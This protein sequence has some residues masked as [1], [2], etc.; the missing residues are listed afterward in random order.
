MPSSKPNRTAQNPRDQISGTSGRLF[1]MLFSIT[2][3]IVW[4]S[5][6][7]AFQAWKTGYDQKSLVGRDTA[8]HIRKLVDSKPAGV[9]TTTWE[10][11]VDH[12]EAMLIAVTGSNLLSVPQI[13]E[14]TT[15]IDQCVEA[16]RRNPEQGPALLRQL[17][18]ELANRAGPVAEIYGRPRLIMP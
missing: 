17:W 11:A 15:E 5:L 2:V 9:S 8:R 14:L 6:W 13:Q 10:D 4:A 1:I 3:L 18:N 16:T 12:A 7:L